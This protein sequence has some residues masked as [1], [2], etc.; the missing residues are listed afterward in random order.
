MKINITDSADKKYYNEFYWILLNYDFLHEEPHSRVHFATTRPLV[1]AIVSVAM[2]LIFVISFLINHHI[3]NVYPI[4]F[5]SIVLVIS[6]FYFFYVRR[7]I[8]K[9]HAIKGKR[10]L[11]I[12]KYFIEVRNSSGKYRLL[13]KDTKNV[14]FNHYTICFIPKDPTKILISTRIEYKKQIKKAIREYSKR[15]LVVDNTKLYEKKPKKTPE[16]ELTEALNELKPEAR[17]LEEPIAKAPTK[18]AIAKSA[19]KTSV[20]AATKPKTGKKSSAVKTSGK[21]TVAKK[22]AAKKT[23]TKKTTAK[24]STKKKVSKT[25]KAE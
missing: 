1:Y 13:W 7:Q 4:I 23:T 18:K 5:F 8:N 21:N 10:S 12:A 11:Q 2:I 15:R 16:K 20:K 17:E 22:T 19:K 6:T 3:I 14:I 24:K 25:A 9:Y